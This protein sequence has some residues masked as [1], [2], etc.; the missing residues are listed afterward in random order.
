MFSHSGTHACH[1][2]PQ[3]LPSGFLKP[4]KL[5]KKSIVSDPVT[6][7]GV[8][9]MKLGFKLCDLENLLIRR[10]HP[11]WDMKRQLASVRL[12]SKSGGKEMLLQFLGGIQVLCRGVE[13]QSRSQNPRNWPTV[14]SVKHIAWLRK[15]RLTSALRHKAGIIKLLFFFFP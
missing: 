5:P 3:T 2:C 9:R 10:H 15:D 6:F 7:P 14:E 1:D 4:T 11:I 13:S 8:G 12:R